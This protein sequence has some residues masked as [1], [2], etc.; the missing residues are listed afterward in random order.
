MQLSF[1]KEHSGS[2]SICW[3]VILIKYITGVY[4]LLIHVRKFNG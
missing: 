3:I 1:R 4:V 2:V